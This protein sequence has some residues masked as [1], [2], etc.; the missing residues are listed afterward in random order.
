MECENCKYGIQDHYVNGA[1]TAVYTCG[2]PNAY[3]IWAEYD[4][5]FCPAEIE[6]NKSLEQTQ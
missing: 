3:E 6:N 1:P 4:G 5:E 2:H